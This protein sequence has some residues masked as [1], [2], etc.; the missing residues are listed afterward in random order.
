MC[1]LHCKWSSSAKRGCCW[2]ALLC[3]VSHVISNCWRTEN[4]KREQNIYYMCRVENALPPYW[5]TTLRVW[6][7]RANQRAGKL[8]S[9]KQ[10]HAGSSTKF[11]TGNMR[12]AAAAA[13]TTTA[14]AAPLSLSCCWGITTKR[15]GKYIRTRRARDEADFYYFPPSTLLSAHSKA[16]FSLWRR[17]KGKWG[18]TA[19]TTVPRAQLSS[20]M[21]FSSLRK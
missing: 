8:L 14:A 21:P 20:Q 13:T 16:A 11:C 5:L 2:R 15:V 9:E 7:A 18:M 3:V 17:D 19:A 10:A 4:G 6:S 1:A 12:A